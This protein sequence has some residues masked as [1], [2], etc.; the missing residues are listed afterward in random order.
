MPPLNQS[1]WALL[2]ASLTAVFGWGLVHLSALVE[3]DRKKRPPVKYFHF[4]SGAMLQRTKRF[5]QLLGNGDV[6][7]L[8]QPQN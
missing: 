2:I 8:R 3:R 5:P 1:L 6:S 7:R 4:P